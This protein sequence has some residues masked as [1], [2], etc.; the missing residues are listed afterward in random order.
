MQ[1]PPGRGAQPW[2]PFNSLLAP[3]PS[4]KSHLSLTAEE[5]VEQSHLGIL[6]PSR[7]PNC[8]IGFQ[9]RGQFNVVRHK[10]RLRNAAVTQSRVRQT[11]GW[12]CAGRERPFR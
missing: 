3:T 11:G 12:H 1:P 2:S 10:L 7:T 9:V 8:G 6:Q 4:K 5:Q